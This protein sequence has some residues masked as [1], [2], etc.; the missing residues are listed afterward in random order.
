MLRRTDAGRRAEVPAGCSHARALHPVREGTMDQLQWISRITRSLVGVALRAHG[1]MQHSIAA[2]LRLRATRNCK[3]RVNKAFSVTRLAQDTISKMFFTTTIFDPGNQLQTSAKLL[4]SCPRAFC[5]C[6]RSKATTT[7]FFAWQNF[8]VETRSTLRPFTRAH[9]SI[10]HA[11]Q[12]RHYV[13]VKASQ[14]CEL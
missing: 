13:I 6:K 3:K 14:S 9:H 1:S 12:L 2:A 7:R 11:L 10:I 5:P 8:I 4:A